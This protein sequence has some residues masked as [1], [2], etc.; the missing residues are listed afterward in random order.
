[1]QRMC[2]TQTSTEPQ[3]WGY[4][5]YCSFKGFYDVL[6][7]VAGVFPETFPKAQNTLLPPCVWAGGRQLHS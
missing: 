4:I 2:S 6:C 1:M 7:E 3:N 5:D